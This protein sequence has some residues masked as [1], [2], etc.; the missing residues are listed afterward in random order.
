MVLSALVD[1]TESKRVEEKPRTFNEALEQVGQRTAQ[2]KAA[3]TELESFVL[4]CFARPEGG[5]GLH[6]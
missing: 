5:L 1:V 2:L 4:R 3:N 6:S